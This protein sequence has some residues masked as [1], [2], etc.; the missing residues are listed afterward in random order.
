MG[1]LSQLSWINNL[2]HNAQKY[3]PEGSDVAVTLEFTKDVIKISVK[4]QGIGIP[5]QDLGSLF[6]P[7][8]RAS[9]VKAIPG[10]GLGLIIVK[11]AV[12][13]H[14]GTIKVASTEGQ[15]TEFR[16]K[17][18]YEKKEESTVQ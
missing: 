3:S 12:E 7:F 9:N 14:G 16:I 2:I 11:R 8:H 13:A 5:K 4:D 6:H 10:T 15:G 18:P 17:L 1:S